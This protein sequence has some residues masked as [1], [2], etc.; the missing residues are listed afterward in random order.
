M[1]LQESRR[2]MQDRGFIGTFAVLA[3]QTGHEF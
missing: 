3:A 1:N 2:R